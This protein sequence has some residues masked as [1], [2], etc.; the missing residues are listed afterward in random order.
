MRF[1]YIFTTVVA[2]WGSLTA[3]NF[4]WEEPVAVSE[5]EKFLHSS[6]IDINNNGQ[7]LAAWIEQSLGGNWNIKARFFDGKEWEDPDQTIMDSASPFEYPVAK[8]NNEG[9]GIAVWYSQTKNQIEYATFNGVAWSDVSDVAITTAEVT[10]LSLSFD[11]NSN[12]L[13][14]YTDNIN[15]LHS[16]MYV[17]GSWSDAEVLAGDSASIS[18]N[19][20]AATPDG[21]H[22]AVW[23]EG[24]GKHPKKSKVSFFVP[25][26]CK[27]M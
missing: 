8:L 9:E 11:D 23:A 14:L 16:K 10:Q 27:A 17:G 20:T 4:E 13:L 1:K 26:G 24:G 19:A 6:S 5:Q 3:T 12:A 22:L 18:L 21:K 15:D 25:Q 7:R 2:L